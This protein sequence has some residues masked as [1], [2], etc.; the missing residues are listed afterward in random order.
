MKY[1][2]KQDIEPGSKLKL[3]RKINS[4]FGTLQSGDIVTLDSISHFP[5]RFHVTDSI[6]KS[7]DIFTYDFEELSEDDD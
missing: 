2:S 3:I 7:W 5:T 1:R 6:G 4:S